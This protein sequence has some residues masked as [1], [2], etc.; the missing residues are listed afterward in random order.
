[1]SGLLNDN[2]V[3]GIVRHM[4]RIVV[5]ISQSKLILFLVNMNWGVG[6]GVEGHLHFLRGAIHSGVLRW[7]RLPMVGWVHWNHHQLIFHAVDPRIRRLL[8]HDF[9]WNVARGGSYLSNSVPCLQTNQLGWNPAN[10]S[11]WNW[12][13]YIYIY[14]G[15]YL[16]WVG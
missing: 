8:H 14:I 5:R 3:V 10:I 6:V 15:I 1:M 12:I 7:L 13:I 2:I 9:T 4:Q 16:T 11:N